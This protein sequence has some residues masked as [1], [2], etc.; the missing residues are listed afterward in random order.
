[1]ARVHKPKGS[2]KEV[3]FHQRVMGG[4]KHFELKYLS[5]VA[6]IMKDPMVVNLD[7]QLHWIR[8]YLGYS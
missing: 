3:S 5:G 1:M 6:Y 4:M 2:M 8:K 7:S